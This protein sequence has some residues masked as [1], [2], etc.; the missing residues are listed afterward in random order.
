MRS[1]GLFADDT[2]RLGQK[3]VLNL[4]VRYDHSRAFFDE[5]PILDKNGSPTG[6][7]APGVDNLFTW[8]KV[9]PRVGITYKVNASGKT[10]VKAHY[11]RYYRGIITGE[12]DNASPSYS[13]RFLF[14]GLY[15]SGGEPLDP[16]LVNDNTNL[17]VSSS[18]DSPRTDQYIAGLE[19]ELFPQVGLQVNY[20]Y[21]NSKDFGA[22]NDVAGAYVPV[23]FTDNV[24]QQPSGNTYTLYQLV[25][26]STQRV[27]QLS[28]D[29]RM[30]ARYHGVSIQVNKRM[31]N[32]WQGTFSLVLSKN[33]GRNGS[34]LGTP[35]NTASSGPNGSTSSFGLPGFGANPN[36]YVNTDGHI[37]SDKPVIAKAQIVYNLPWGMMV[38]AN[39]QH[40]TGRLWSR[41]LRVDTLGYPFTPNILMEPNTG[42]RRVADWNLI[43]V[44]IEKAF[45]LDSRGT[46]AAVFGDILNLTNSDA[47]ESIGSRD[48]ENQ[49]FGLPTRFIAPRRLMLGAKIRF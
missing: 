13:P 7:T 14:S 40:Q 24:G 45:K 38:G 44:R 39:L 10:V 9:S 20:I 8:D 26:D 31:A 29:P 15:G 43:D 18:M 32:H 6:E 47:Y 25:S 21:K 33:T 34:S 19:Q 37:I 30:F 22:W 5:K 48:A 11:G 35:T 42:D 2:Y 1:T 12:F 23:Q 27:F 28:S 49:S 4:G 16:E 36:D 41:V 46:N 3:I 17:K